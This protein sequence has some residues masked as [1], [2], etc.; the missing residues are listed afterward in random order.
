LNGVIFGGIQKNSLIDYPG[1]ICCVIFF[2][3]CN[4]HCPYCH[5]PELAKGMALERWPEEKVYDFLE[6]RKG[7]LEG[8]VIS[9]GEPCIHPDVI[10]VCQTIRKMGYPVKMDTNGSCPDV[11]ENLIARGLL[12]YVAMDIKTIPENY[13]R[14]IQN[15]CDTDS[16]ISSIRLIIESGLQHEFRTTCI[17]PLISE[18]MVEKICGLIQGADRYVLQQFRHK[19]V[20]NPGFFQNN[21]CTVSSDELQRFCSIARKWVDCCIIR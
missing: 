6:Q 3:G 11:L 13:G 17:K 5:N 21:D 7:F 2:S 9:G 18:S 1:K 16:I 10:H 4:F 12:D 20:L 8:V 19:H 15:N 14:Y